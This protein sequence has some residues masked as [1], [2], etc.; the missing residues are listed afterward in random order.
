MS[1]L[2]SQNGWYLIGVKKGDTLQNTLSSQ[3]NLSVYNF[4]VTNAYCVNNN[5]FG[6]SSPSPGN[7][8]VTEW[9]DL[10][11]LL[12]LNM[13]YSLGVWVNISLGSEQTTDPTD[14]ISNTYPTTGRVVDGYVSGAIL[15][16]RDINVSTS[17]PLGIFDT[18]NISF[19]DSIIIATGG[20]AIDTGLPSKILKTIARSDA[21]SLV[22]SPLTTLICEVVQQ[23]ITYLDNV[24]EFVGSRIGLTKEDIIKDPIQELKSFIET[25][26]GNINILLLCYKINNLITIANIITGSNNYSIIF[27]AFAKKLLNLSSSET[28][29]LNSETI[30]KEI[31]EE[32]NINVNANLVANS[33]SIYGKTMTKLD[34]LVYTDAYFNAAAFVRIIKENNDYF[35]NQTN[36]SALT[37]SVDADS[38]ASNI[39]SSSVS[40]SVGIIIP[41]YTPPTTPDTSEPEPEPVTEVLTGKPL[42]FRF[43]N[44]Q[45]EWRKISDITYVNRGVTYPLSEENLYIETINMNFPIGSSITMSNYATNF[46]NT[47]ANGFDINTGAIIGTLAWQV[48]SSENAPQLPGTA[49]KK[50]CDITAEWDITDISIVVKNR[51]KDDGTEKK[52]DLLTDEVQF[53]DANNIKD[54][55]TQNR[56]LKRSDPTYPIKDTKIDSSNLL[57]LN[58]SFV[59]S[60]N[61][62]VNYELIISDDSHGSLFPNAMFNPAW[63]SLVDWINN[64]GQ[65]EKPGFPFAFDP[66]FNGDDVDTQVTLPKTTNSL[67]STKILYFN[68]SFVSPQNS[69]VNYELITSDASHGSLFPN[70]MFNPAWNSLVDWI[71]N[72]GQPEKPGFPKA[73]PDLN[74]PDP[75]EPEPAPIDNNPIISLNGGN[76]I[77]LNQGDV[78]DDLGANVYDAEDGVLTD[79]IIVTVTNSIGNPIN[80]YNITNV[81]GTYL[82]TYTVTDSGGN[83]VS[84]TRTVVVESKLEP[85]PPDPFSDIYIIDDSLRLRNFQPSDRSIYNEVQDMIND[86]DNFNPF[87]DDF[88]IDKLTETQINKISEKLHLNPLL[89]KSVICLLIHRN[90]SY[91]L[92]YLNVPMVIDNEPVVFPSEPEPTNELFVK[93][94]KEN[95]FNF[96]NQVNSDDWEPMYN[97]SNGRL[98]LYVLYTTEPLPEPEPSE[99]EPVPSEPEPVPS[100]PEPE[101][102]P[103]FLMVEEKE[104]IIIDY[105]FNK[106]G[107][108]LNEIKSVVNKVINTDD[109]FN[110]SLGQELA[111]NWYLEI[112]IAGTFEPEPFVVSIFLDDKHPT[113]G[114]QGNQLKILDSTGI[115][116]LETLPIDWDNYTSGETTNKTYELVLTKGETY[117]VYVNLKGTGFGVSEISWSISYNSSILL[118]GGDYDFN[119]VGEFSAGTFIVDPLSDSSLEAKNKRNNQTALIKKYDL[120]FL[121]EDN[122]NYLYFETNPEFTPRNDFTGLSPFTVRF[123]TKHTS[124]LEPEPEPEPE[125]DIKTGVYNSFSYTITENEVTITDYPVGATGQIVIPSIINGKPVKHIGSDA[126][127]GCT[128][129]NSISIPDSVTSIGQ[130]GFYNCAN[131]QSI[132]IPD[133]VTSIG[134]YAFSYCSNIESV[135]FDG[136]STITKIGE[137]CFQT[138]ANLESITI[139]DSVTSIDTYAF[140]WCTDLQSIEIPDRVTSIGNNAFKGSGLHS[141]RLSSATAAVL[142]ITPDPNGQTFFGKDGVNII[143]TDAEPEPELN[144]KL[145]DGDYNIT[146]NSLENWTWN[147]YNIT[148][149]GDNITFPLPNVDYIYVWDSNTNT[150]IDSQYH[151]SVEFDENNN[152][153]NILDEDGTT[154]YI[155]TGSKQFE[156]T[157]SE[158]NFLFKRHI[159]GETIGHEINKAFNDNLSN[160]YYLEN[161]PEGGGSKHLFLDSCDKILESIDE[162]ERKSQTQLVIMSENNYTILKST[163]GALFNRSYDEFYV[164]Y[165]NYLAFR[166]NNEGDWNIIYVLS[167]VPTRI[168]HFSVEVTVTTDDKNGNPINITNFFNFGTT[169]QDLTYANFHNLK[170]SN[171]QSI[172][173]YIRD[174]EFFIYYD[175]KYYKIDTLYIAGQYQSNGNLDTSSVLGDSLYF[176]VVNPD[177]TDS[178]FG[179]LVGSTITLEFH[180]KTPYSELYKSSTRYPEILTLNAEPI[181][182]HWDYAT[183]TATT[184][185]YS[186]IEDY[187]KFKAEKTETVTINIQTLHDYNV[188]ITWFWMWEGDNG[189]TVLG[190][191]SHDWTSTGGSGSGQNVNTNDYGSIKWKRDVEEGK[192]YYI[193]FTVNDPNQS[194]GFKINIHGMADL[195]VLLDECTYNYS[196]N[197]ITFKIKNEGNGVTSGWRLDGTYFDFHPVIEVTKTPNSESVTFSSLKGNMPIYVERNDVSGGY[198]SN[199]LDIF[200]KDTYYLNETIEYNNITTND[201]GLKLITYTGAVTNSGGE[202]YNNTGLPV[203]TSFIRED[204]VLKTSMWGTTNGPYIYLSNGK[205]LKKNDELTFNF[206]GNFEVGKTYL[207]S[208]DDISVGGVSQPS[209]KVGEGDTIETYAD[210]DSNPSNN[211]FVFTYYDING[212]SSIKLPNGYYT[213]KVTKYMKKKMDTVYTDNNNMNVLP[214]DIGDESIIKSSTSG[215]MLEFPSGGTMQYFLD[216]PNAQDKKYSVGGLEIFIYQPDSNDNNTYIMKIGIIQ[217]PSQDSDYIYVILKSANQAETR[218]T[219]KELT[220][221]V[222]ENRVIDPIYEEEWFKFEVLADQTEYTIQTS[223][224]TDNDQINEVN[225]TVI[226]IYTSLGAADSEYDNDD[227]DNATGNYSSITETFNAGTHYIKVRLFD[228]GYSQVGGYNIIVTGPEPNPQGTTHE[229]AID[230]GE[231]AH[232]RI[233]IETLYGSGGAEFVD[234]VD[235]SDTELAIYNHD[236]TRRSYDDDSGQNT[237][238]FISQTFESGD[239]GKIFYIVMG[240]YNVV[241]GPSDFNVSYDTTSTL[242]SSGKGD[243]I[244]QIKDNNSDNI[245]YTSN[246]TLTDSQSIFWFKFTYKA[247]P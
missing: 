237:L 60:Q 227:S 113:D 239:N 74:I 14:P 47:T 124:L 176:K 57:Y 229:N 11:N 71:N 154:G 241:M 187:Y 27:N 49:W 247:P 102:A 151:I 230:I 125:P 103:R 67:E 51:Q 129:L 199:D 122:V 84:A 161:I 155:E 88:T 209:P 134:N 226:D 35:S 118:S 6:S 116:V 234:G 169:I 25:G 147:T 86:D 52:S 26:N 117:N 238:S 179:N 216:D 109:Y 174:N 130:A 107:L 146:W 190:P 196:T 65:P 198:Y 112:D 42:Q 166:Y 233:N 56:I 12:T 2:I 77:T 85:D 70:A 162:S 8:T 150:Y 69:S 142:N 80:L 148:V 36:I 172:R 189:D 99:P 157:F 215:D 210:N 120:T 171:P 90:T 225:D 104:I 115:D 66:S 131:L 158:G 54:A 214:I 221:N 114:W 185:N 72:N 38:I 111:E 165:D 236:G 212:K 53:G 30:L 21:E 137:G 89:G 232:M 197:V 41:G 92:Y 207:V 182:K 33:S 192:I 39:I 31:I 40:Q 135:T 211:Y 17:D 79:N 121:S 126:F 219:A 201:R 139:P 101:P 144:N 94:D 75:E 244:L 43:N 208:A 45:L 164:G 20:T 18:S 222:G 68:K 156:Y 1:Y 235:V 58:D 108:I 13:P 184:S 48:K 206:K 200:F 96:L 44:N 29:D 82:I 188:N 145:E 22:L 149:D 217:N 78:Y 55:N 133:S 62:S 175:S 50:I 224:W 37:G 76:I 15:T 163:S 87:P 128:L 7:F 143:I 242:S 223:G 180:N 203:D 183:T 119:Q 193:R 218:Y 195:K 59:S 204:Y 91:I 106:I 93:L 16:Q 240:G 100:E 10:K 63:N 34:N 95:R 213:Y 28:I 167:S 202:I 160:C 123:Y 81:P 19:D 140:G 5:Y 110:N 220:V 246:Y 181:S 243:V 32:S 138:C 141:V 9:K 46:E 24:E 194:G 152:R 159:N 105:S 127:K 170:T 173:D 73:F 191:N 98:E 168:K 231:I 245:L 132:T 4:T 228:G 64:N 23:D 177:G 3:V 205:V 136:T 61:N 186:I 83:E 97:E 153:Y 178:D